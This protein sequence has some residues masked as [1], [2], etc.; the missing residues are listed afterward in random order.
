[1][2][3]IRRGGNGSMPIFTM[4]LN[5]YKTQRIML[6]GGINMIRKKFDK[7]VVRNVQETRKDG[8]C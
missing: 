8:K 4:V 5:R 1:M 2:I 3:I 7:K 6:I